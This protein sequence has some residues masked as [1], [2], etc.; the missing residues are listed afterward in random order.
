MGTTRSTR[1]LLPIVAGLS[2]L[3][4]LTAQWFR[5]APIGWPF[6]VAIYFFAWWIM[7]FA[8]LPLGVRTQHDAGEV[9]QG[10]SAGAPVDPRMAKVLAWTTIVGSTVFCAVLLALRVRLIPLDV[11]N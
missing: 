4:A 7:L 10:T 9:I 8:V 11:A 5:L 3:V 6:A 2:V 1:S